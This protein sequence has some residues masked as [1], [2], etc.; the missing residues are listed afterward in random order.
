MG[1]D[2]PQCCCY[3]EIMVGDIAIRSSP[4]VIQSSCPPDAHKIKN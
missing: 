1:I 2:A 3:I 4:K